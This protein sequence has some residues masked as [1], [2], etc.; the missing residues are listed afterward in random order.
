MGTL[1]LT[2]LWALFA[3][4][5]FF[6]LIFS[7]SSRIPGRALSCSNCHFGTAFF[8]VMGFGVSAASPV[9]EAVGATVVLCLDN[10]TLLHSKHLN[11]FCFTHSWLSGHHI[12]AQSCLF[13]PSSFQKI[14]VYL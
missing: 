6:L 13:I 12:S 11:S 5:Q 14:P 3:F 2:K 8:N 1:L 4:H 9:S 7:F 10:N